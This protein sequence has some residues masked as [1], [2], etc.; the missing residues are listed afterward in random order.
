MS[1]K[2]QTNPKE[3]VQSKIDERSLWVCCVDS[4]GKRKKSYPRRAEANVAVNAL[5]V[6]AK[7]YRCLFNPD[8]FHVT[9]KIKKRKLDVV[10]CGYIVQSLKY[11]QDK[12]ETG[13]QAIKRKVEGMTSETPLEEIIAVDIEWNNLS[14]EKKKL[15]KKLKYFEDFLR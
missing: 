1:Q 11:R 3:P 12:V 9:T 6:E 7:S 15:P 14:R 8:M 4:K 5:E 2:Y 13:I 10:T